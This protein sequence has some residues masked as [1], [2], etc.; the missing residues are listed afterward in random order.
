MINL[1][2]RENVTMKKLTLVVALCGALFLVLA[3]CGQQAYDDTKSGIRF[4]NK[5]EDGAEKFDP[6][7][8]KCPVCGGQPIKKGLHAKTEKG[9]IYFDKKQC[10]EKFKEEPKKHLKKYRREMSPYGGGSGD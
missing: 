8:Y 10:A 7:Q 2:D 3:G 5:I 4:A 1:Y 6:N 9:R